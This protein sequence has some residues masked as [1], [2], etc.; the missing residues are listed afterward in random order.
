MIRYP[1]CDSYNCWYKQNPD[2]L[3]EY[4]E[5]KTIVCNND[6]PTL[7]REIACAIRAPYTFQLCDVCYW[8]YYASSHAN[9]E[10]CGHIMDG[11]WIV[12]EER[13]AYCRLCVSDDDVKKYLL[14]LCGGDKDFMILKDC[15][16]QEIAIHEIIVHF[17]VDHEN[18]LLSTSAG[19]ITVKE[20][21]CKVVQQKTATLLQA[22][23]QQQ[24]HKRKHSTSLEEQLVQLFDLESE[25]IAWRIVSK[26]LPT[27]TQKLPEFQK[28]KRAKTL[29]WLL[30]RKAFA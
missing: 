16:L 13:D 4:K 3:N 21:L 11:D 26:H 10:L 5:S 12:L 19:T 8:N 24:Q 28:H 14:V 18:V 15:K 7:E 23:Q 6:D 1:A 2:R 25:K 9:C 17:T 30:D 27:D 20:L 22:K 29:L